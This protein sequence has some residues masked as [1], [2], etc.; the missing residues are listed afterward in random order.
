MK[1]NIGDW[2]DDPSKERIVKVRIDDYD[3]W[4]V[5]TTLAE[6]I[7]P[8]LV[9]FRE[10]LKGYPFVY[11]ADVP[12]ELADKMRT[13]EIDEHSRTEEGAY[14]EE[15][16]LWILDEMIHAFKYSRSCEDIMEMFSSGEHDMYFE[17][18]EINGQKM[19]ELKKTD[20]DTFQYDIEGARAF[21]NR[22]K[23]GRILFGKYYQSLWN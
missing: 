17:P 2:P 8:L 15:A 21:E 22:L 1:V 11:Y 3:T 19:Y 23:N 10:N 18:I 13:A 7:Y 9:K 12:E 16:W 20:K 14:F 4:D 5:S 6:I